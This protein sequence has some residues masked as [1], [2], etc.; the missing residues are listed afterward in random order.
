MKSFIR[1]IFEISDIFLKKPKK[2]VRLTSF[3]LILNALR[4]SLSSDLLG[5]PDRHAWHCLPSLGNRHLKDCRLPP[6]SHEEILLQS[7]S[8]SQAQSETRL[9]VSTPQAESPMLD[10]AMP[11]GSCCNGG[12]LQKNHYRSQRYLHPRP[13]QNR[14][15][16]AAGS[17][18]GR[19]EPK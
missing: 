11:C 15:Q 12:I 14:P 4:P 2:E 18:S 10:K 19:K 7:H 1:Q 16:R 13:D 9:T 17:S 5:F 3:D 6:S 8:P